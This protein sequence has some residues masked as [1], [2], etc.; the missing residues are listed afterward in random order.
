MKAFL[1][2]SVAACTLL[3][4][5]FVHAD[6]KCFSTG[7]GVSCVFNFKTHPIDPNE[8]YAF[9]CKA[10]N[11]V[12]RIFL[13]SHH[14]LATGFSKDTGD[15]L[16]G[17]GGKPIEQFNQVH[18]DVKLNKPSSKDI[19]NITVLNQAGAGDISCEPGTGGRPVMPGDYGR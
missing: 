10:P 8:H 18:F 19:R 12:K 17:E 9:F 16:F 1:Y 14:V 11:T 15:L 7:P 3:M 5:D 6:V 13:H 2:G 4:S